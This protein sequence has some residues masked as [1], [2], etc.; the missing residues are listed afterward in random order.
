VHHP[1]RLS[2]IDASSATRNATAKDRG[3]SAC[4][5]VGT[6]GTGQLGVYTE[7][8]SREWL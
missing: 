7:L 5:G 6:Q 2:S 4:N 3:A 8:T 1:S